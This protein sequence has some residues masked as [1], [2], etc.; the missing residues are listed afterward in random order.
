MKVDALRVL[1]ERRYTLCPDR[2]VEGDAAVLWYPQWGSLVWNPS[3]PAS[4]HALAIKAD[5]L[6]RSLDFPRQL[7]VWN[8]KGTELT[9]QTV[10]EF[11]SRCAE[12]VFAKC[13]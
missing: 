4:V 10:P 13:F 5:Q 6:T 9:G 1:L 8:S 2:R 11:Q 12:E 3:S 7:T